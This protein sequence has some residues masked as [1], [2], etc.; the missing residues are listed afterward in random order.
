VRSLTEACDSRQGTYEHDTAVV[1]QQKVFVVAE[2]S[3]G[4]ATVV[5]KSVERE[6][7]SVL[8]KP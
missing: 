4:E 2:H 8:R 6:V 5:V 3:V 1:T 7:Q